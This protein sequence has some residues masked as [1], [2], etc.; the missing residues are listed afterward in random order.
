MDFC[1]ILSCFLGSFFDFLLSWINPIMSTEDDIQA[2]NDLKALCGCLTQLLARSTSFGHQVWTLA[3]KKPPSLSKFHQN[4]RRNN[5][6]WLARKH[7]NLYDEKVKVR[8]W[9]F[10][11]HLRCQDLKTEIKIPLKP[12]NK[13]LSTSSVE[14]SS[15]KKNILLTFHGFHSKIC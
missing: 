8:Q 14:I 4:I 1:C 10:T 13:F 5:A 11:D 15:K 9:Y 6:S 7:C 3:T 2:K 12:S